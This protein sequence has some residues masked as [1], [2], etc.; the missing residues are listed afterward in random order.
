MSYTSNFT[1]PDGHILYKGQRLPEELLSEAKNVLMNHQLP[2]LPHREPR[3]LVEALLFCVGSQYCSFERPLE[4]LKSLHECNDEDL[5]KPQ[6]LAAK[7]D[8]AGLPYNDRFVPALKLA[9]DYEGGIEALAEDALDSPR[10]TRRKVAKL[11]KFLAPKTFSLWYLCLGGKD[12]ICIDRHVARAVA[13][14]R[15]HGLGIN[16]AKKFRVPQARPDGRK[17]IEYPR[18]REY[19]RIEKRILEECT[20][21]ELL[22]EGSSRPNGALITTLFWVDGA[23]RARAENEETPS[24]LLFE[25]PYSTL[26]YRGSVI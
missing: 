15:T 25:S 19:E 2:S 4:F 20:N 5:W 18:I 13:G 12:L 23:S 6:L 1:K 9:H 11:H 22:Q 8:G 10:A 14:P 17:I 16:V 7:A 3:Y 21:E 26:K 24:R